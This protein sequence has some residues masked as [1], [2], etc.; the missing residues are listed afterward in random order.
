[1]FV[2]PRAS[3]E[4]EVVDANPNP[5]RSS[6]HPCGWRKF[7]N[8]LWVCAFLI[9]SPLVLPVS[10]V[11]TKAGEFRYRRAIKTAKRIGRFLEPA[12]VRERVVSG[13]GLLLLGPV[14]K[15]QLEHTYWTTL[16]IEEASKILA[17]RRPPRH[18]AIF[19]TAGDALE[20]LVEYVE[21]Q[22]GHPTLPV[23]LIRFTRQRIDRITSP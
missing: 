9:F 18:P 1:M 14:S 23:P 22:A 7:K 11:I 12:V 4:C 3:L 17:T 21:L 19:L 6:P 15:S 5:S 2:A 8:V 16:S 13:H 20:G 10:V